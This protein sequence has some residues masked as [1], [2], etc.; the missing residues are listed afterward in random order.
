MDLVREGRATPKD[1]AARD[2]AAKEAPDADRVW[3]GAPKLAAR[4]AQRAGELVSISAA[5]GKGVIA[6]PDKFIAAAKT[7]GETLGALAGADTPEATFTTRLEYF[8]QVEHVVRMFEGVRSRLLDP[9][10]ISDARSSG[11]NREIL[12]MAD[13]LTKE[14]SLRQ[15]VE[16]ALRH[17]LG[18]QSAGGCPPKRALAAFVRAGST[19]GYGE[20]SARL[21]DAALGSGLTADTARAQAARAAIGADVVASEWRALGD[22]HPIAQLGTMRGIVARGGA[23]DPPTP[24]QT[25]DLRIPGSPFLIYEP[26]KILRGT[27]ATLEAGLTTSL[28]RAYETVRRGVGPG[29]VTGGG[30]RPAESVRLV[31]REDDGPGRVAGYALDPPPTPAHVIAGG[32]HVWRRAVETPD[33]WG[34]AGDSEIGRAHV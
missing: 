14:E 11:G 32:R 31:V 8:A 17:L 15:G 9:G 28:V 24:H 23:E 5:V 21:L 16:G 3:D 18:A 4:L 6:E 33:L 34:A 25:L 1:R 26:S 29:P 10:L 30:E 19:W 22:T 13:A 7:P 27:G 12:A 20:M 2:S